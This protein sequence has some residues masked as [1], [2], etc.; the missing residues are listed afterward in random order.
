[1][2]SHCAA[3]SG[4]VGH[5]SRRGKDLCP[6]VW[7]GKDAVEVVLPPTGALRATYDPPPLLVLQ[8]RNTT[9]GTN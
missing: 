1:M 3:T 4:K 6:E 9:H 7:Q 2:P 5:W 8:L